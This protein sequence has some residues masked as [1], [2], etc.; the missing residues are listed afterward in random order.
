[1]SMSVVLIEASFDLFK[2][3]NKNSASCMSL[4]YE[5]WA[6]PGMARQGP[7]PPG[8]GLNRSC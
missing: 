5:Q 2:F 4:G 8:L 1:M 3:A 7:G 6:M